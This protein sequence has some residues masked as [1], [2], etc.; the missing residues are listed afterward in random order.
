MGGRKKKRN[1]DCNHHPHASEHPVPKSL[2]DRLL[3]KTPLCT[4][5]ISCGANTGEKLQKFRYGKWLSWGPLRAETDSY[6]S[7]DGCFSHL[8]GWALAAGPVW[9][10]CGFE[11]T[12]QV[13]NLTLCNIS[14]SL[15]RIVCT[16][17][18]FNFFLGRMW[19]GCRFQVGRREW[20]SREKFWRGECIP[21][22]SCQLQSFPVNPSESSQ[23]HTG[24]SAKKRCWW[25]CSSRVKTPS[26]SRAAWFLPVCCQLFNPWMPMKGAAYTGA[27]LK[28]SVSI[29]RRRIQARENRC[30][31]C[32]LLL[33]L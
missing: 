3:S 11:L 24:I 13:P 10:D 23:F 2:T 28:V 31:K 33:L 30:T 19:P 16:S 18:A 1:S 4:I 8:E 27:D 17:W 21:T 5:V 25:L 12:G 14:I 26:G 22:Q 9:L 20:W 15:C 6:Q 29:A 32:L 7:K